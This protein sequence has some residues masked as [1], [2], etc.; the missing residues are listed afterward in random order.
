MATGKIN[1]EIDELRIFSR[2]L[3][4]GEIRCLAGDR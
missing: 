3:S 1:G 4:E 2:A